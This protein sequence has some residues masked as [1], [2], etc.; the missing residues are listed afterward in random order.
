MERI[1][2][3]IKTLFRFKNCCCSRKIIKSNCSDEVS[4][5]DPKSIV[6]WNIQ[7]LFLFMKKIKISNV[8][9]KIREFDSDVICLQEAFEESIKIKIINELKDIYPYYLCGCIDRKY[10]VGEDSGLL[11]LSKYNINFKKEYF[12]NGCEFPD[13]LA[14]KTI[15]Y[16]SV[17]NYNFSNTHVQ[18][19][20]DFIA[21]NQVKEI[22]NQSPFQDFIIVGDLNHCKADTILNVEKNNS[23][24][25]WND[26]ILDYILPIKCDDKKIDVNVITMDLT[27]ISDHLPIKG[28]I[29]KV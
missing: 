15:L 26:E 28:I 23:V 5:I 25:T 27:N 6:S 16:F 17:G 9:Q 4:K 12:L 1:C 11:I 8:I 7:G 14:N 3:V 13:N 20:N 19:N 2:N 18:A 29:K 22:I 24:Y 10:N 21:G